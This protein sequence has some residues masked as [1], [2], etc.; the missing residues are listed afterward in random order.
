MTHQFSRTIYNIILNHLSSFWQQKS[1]PL[2]IQTRIT[3]VVYFFFI[4]IV[5]FLLLEYRLLNNNDRC[6]NTG[7]FIPIEYIAI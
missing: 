2:S 3:G 5:Q 1:M 6:K 7:Q 4:D